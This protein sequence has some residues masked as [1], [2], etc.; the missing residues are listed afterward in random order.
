M[1]YRKA[2]RQAKQIE[3]LISAI[4]NVI[5]ALFSLAF[6]IIKGLF[7][8][9]MLIGEKTFI[10]GNLRWSPNKTTPNLS[11]NKGETIDISPTQKTINIS[12]E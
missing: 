5:G 11:S 2:K 3:E 12:K 1:S 9:I 10:K 7:K 8:L 6:W 4:F